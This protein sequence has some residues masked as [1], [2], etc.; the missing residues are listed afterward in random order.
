MKKV[1]K[2]VS[3]VIEDKNPVCVFAAKE[4]SKYLGATGVKGIIKSEKSK[5]GKVVSL[6][7]TD[8]FEDD[9]FVIKTTDSGY[10]ILGSNPVSVLFG[11]YRFLY[12]HGYRWIR[13]GKRG[14]I[15]PQKVDLGKKINIKEKA[16]YKYRT[17]CIEGA[18]SVEHVID[19]ID[20]GAKNYMNGYFIQFD[21][22][23]H[24]F[25]RWY[26]HPDNP[27]IKPEKFDKSDAEKAIQKI[28]EEIKKRGMRLE[29]MGHGWT[30]RAIGIEGEGWEGEENKIEKIPE[31]KRN[32]IAMIDGK[33]EFFRNVPLNT[34]LCYSNPEVRS[35]ITDTI[36]EYAEKHPEIDA[37]HFWLA[38]GSNNNCEC[39]NCKKQRVS[40]F[41]VMMLNELDEK[42]TLRNIS[43]RI[44]F[45]IYVDLLWPPEKEKIK[46][47]DRFII[48]FAPITRSYLQ[49]FA[50]TKPEEG[51]KPYIKNKLEFPKNAGDNVEY[52]KKW[53]EMFNGDGVDFDYHL[54]W[55]CYYDLNHFTLAKVLYKDI[56]NLEN[57]KLTGF[58]SCQNQRASFPTNLLMDVMAR[59]LWNKN[60]S[61]NKIIVETFSDAFGKKHSKDVIRFL[62]KMSEL[63]RPFFEPVF[64]PQ[65]DEKRIEA[66]IKNIEKM[67]KLCED[68]K[69]IVK[70]NLDCSE[71]AICWSWK[72]L[73]SY[74]KLLNFLLP[75]FTSYLKREPDCKEKFEKVFEFVRKN[76]KTLHP[77]FDVSTFM[78]VLNWRI[79]EAQGIS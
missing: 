49:S 79:N 44:V 29:K 27:Y 71:T 64:I 16:S 63:N 11:V 74:L 62:E 18:A 2:S 32:W 66:G 40:D 46:N 25:K 58:I 78:K 50:D 52:L 30:C 26:L 6:G 24:F 75:A 57:M 67:K 3:I 35:A 36:V 51:I 28:V 73:D 42:L 37:I 59:T 69:N 22:G 39:E 20:W 34:N 77:A 47:P 7:L 70:K 12:E 45:L 68:F 53:Q 31:E 38:D 60:I 72:Y 76:E 10:H 55:A 13:P 54:I 48:M 61:F 41:Y 43:T 56:K 21:Y 23:T 14:E 15:I 1:L 5:S 9:G 33:R 8:N 19:L 65:P 4:L 17:L